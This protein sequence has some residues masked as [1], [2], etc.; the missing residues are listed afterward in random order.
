METNKSHD[1]LCATWKTKKVSGK[2]QSESK[3]L[4]LEG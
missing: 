1:L 3:A 2:I 4:E